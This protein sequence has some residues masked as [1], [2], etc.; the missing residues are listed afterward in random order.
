MTSSVQTFLF[1]AMDF[2]T[3][4]STVGTYIINSLANA[5][6]KTTFLN[7]RVVLLRFIINLQISENSMVGEN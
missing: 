3:L 6:G 5:Y 7:I 4:E 1:E 2:W